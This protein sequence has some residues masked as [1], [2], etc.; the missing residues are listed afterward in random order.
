MMSAKVCCI[1]DKEMIRWWVQLNTFK[2]YDLDFFPRMA[3]RVLDK[4]G[5]GMIR[6]EVLKHLMVNI[7]KFE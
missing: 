3:F 1:D 4:Q 2:N 5:H 7:G 6:T